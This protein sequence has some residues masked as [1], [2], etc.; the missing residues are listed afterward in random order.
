[1]LFAFVFKKWKQDSRNFPRKKYKS[2]PKNQKTKI[3]LRRGW[4]SWAESKGLN[5]DIVKCEAKELD[6]CLSRVF[7]EIRKSDGSV[8]E[9]GSLRL[10]L[11]ASTDT[12]NI[13]ACV[14]WRFKQFECLLTKRRRFLSCLSPRFLVV[15]AL[16][17]AASPLS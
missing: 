3:L 4:K 13:I 2:W 15:L 16:V 8:Y 1:M 14:A 10:M 6:E 5:D 11:A 12:S 9:P 7:V 17:V